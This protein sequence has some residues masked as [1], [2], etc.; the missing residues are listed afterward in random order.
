[1]LAT[2]LRKTTARCYI[3]PFALLLLKAAPA[4]AQTAS[5]PKIYIG[6]QGFAGNYD[7]I[8]PRETSS[9]LIAAKPVQVTVGV[10]FA[11]QWAVQ[12]GWVGS[13]QVFRTSGEYVNT[14]GKLTRYD[15]RDEQ[16]SM[17]F[18][19]L[20]RYTITHK[21]AHRI[22][23]D[24]VAG[25][26]IVRGTYREQATRWDDGQAVYQLTRANQT[27]NAI[28]TAGPAIRCAV[29]SRVELLG[30]ATLNKT[31][32]GR[33]MQTGITTTVSAGIQ[34]VFTRKQ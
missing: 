28:L 4:T 17:A 2:L 24:G 32:S 5:S 29:G 23:F 19:V 18:P 11:P 15:S 10:Q 33:T 9:R 8:Y 14:T 22:Q 6:V 20:L 1:M 27:V 13:K 34:Y 30:M 25:L 12:V 3:L 7:L 31:L 16:G 21:A 26:T